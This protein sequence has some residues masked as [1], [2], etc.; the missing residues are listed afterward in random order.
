MRLD[1]D[2]QKALNVERAK[3]PKVGD[4]WREFFRADAT[5]LLVS[6]RHVTY[7]DHHGE[8]HTVTRQRFN[9]WLSYRSIP[10]TWADVEA[11]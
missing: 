10:G 6:P 11:A 9:K 7:K 5:V 8:T 1:R 3:K 4:I 2:A